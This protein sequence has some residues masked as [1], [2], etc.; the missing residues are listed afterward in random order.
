MSFENI[1]PEQL[2]RQR[3]NGS[4][5]IID[6]RNRSDYIREHIPGAICIPYEELR[7]N[8]PR[9]KNWTVQCNRRFGHSALILYC[10]RG[11]TSLRASR[12]LNNLGFV[13]KNVYGGIS[14][15]R[16]PKVKETAAS[17]AEQRN[18]VDGI[19]KSR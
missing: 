15:Y 6:L 11:N 18:L 13:V 9:L 10:E 7:G 5:L 16:G 12:D 1:R 17:A 3:G 14:A 4:G 2:F 8:I 19:E